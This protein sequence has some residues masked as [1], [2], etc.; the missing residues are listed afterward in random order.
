EYDGDAAY[1]A[2]DPI[3]R[4]MIVEQHDITLSTPSLEFSSREWY[5]SNSVS[6]LAT[7]SDAGGVS[8]SKQNEADTPSSPSDLLV[9]FNGDALDSAVSDLTGS[10]ASAAFIVSQDTGADKSV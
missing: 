4:E 7:D 1:E 9:T 5:K 3:S 2:A 10:E 8:A 6:T